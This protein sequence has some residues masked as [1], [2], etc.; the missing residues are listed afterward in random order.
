MEVLYNQKKAFSVFRR[1][2]IPKRTAPF[3]MLMGILNISPDSFSDEANG[4][5][6]W[7]PD[8]ALKRAV[9]MIEDGA[10]I[11]DIGAVSTRPGAPCITPEEEAARYK[12]ILPLLVKECTVPLSADTHRL[13]PAQVSLDCG[14]DI[15]NDV[16]ALRIVP[17]DNAIPHTHW[18]DDE[19]YAL[20]AAREGAA[21]VLMHATAIPALRTSLMPA[22]ADIV[23]EISDFLVQRA[24]YAEQM[25]IQHE[26]ICLD[27]G[28]GFGKNYEDNCHLLRR[29]PELKEL[30]Y[31]LLAG[32]SRKSLIGDALGFSVHQRLYPSVALAVLSVWQGG[33][34]IRV[35][36]VFETRSAIDM[37]ASICF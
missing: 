4:I 24:C 19:E 26:Y 3:P 14:V 7:T 21:I 10:D 20:L 30:G 12:K 2:Q 29:L 37:I 17:E 1:G 23:Q 33:N 32:L 36:D 8:N 25:G 13:L 22:G 28:F 18:K 5:M 31:P 11:I 6:D 34:I 15:L 16:S 35:H 9:R 27:P